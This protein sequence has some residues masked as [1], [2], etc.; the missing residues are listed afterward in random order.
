MSGKGPYNNDEF[1]VNARQ[2]VL[3]S[4]H[5]FVRRANDGKSF[6][7]SISLEMLHHFRAKYC[8]S[9]GSIPVVHDDGD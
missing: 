8:L 4:K 6:R 2:V 9:L 7:G 1:P 5:H 3:V